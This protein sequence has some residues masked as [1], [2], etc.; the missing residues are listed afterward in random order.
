MK[1]FRLLSISSFFKKNEKFWLFGEKGLYCYDKKKNESRTF[2]M[3]DGLPSNDFT[4]SAFVYDKHGRCVA[5]TSN[6]L[7][8]FF[9][10]DVQ[11]I[12]NS[13]RVQLTALY[14]NDVFYT[15]YMPIL[16]K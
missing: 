13:P 11:N 1:E 4:L 15:L 10:S 9:P 2:T 3:E 16:M 5:G 8:S 7:V 12:A 6:G 14:I